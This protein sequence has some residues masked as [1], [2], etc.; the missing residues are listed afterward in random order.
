MKNKKLFT[1]T[2][3]LILVLATLSLAACGCSN[4][5][6][7]SE[8]LADF[9][10][11]DIS[12]YTGLAGYTGENPFVEVTV[13]DVHEMVEKKSTF[14]LFVSYKSC[15]WC[16]AVI[17]ELCEVA[18]E[19]NI[20][21]ANID[22]RKN[23]EWKSNLDIDD[24]DLFVEI[25]GDYLQYDTDGIKHLYVPHMFFV[26]DGAVVYEHQGAI[27]E[28]GSDPMTEKTPEM[29]EKI[30]EVFREGFGQLK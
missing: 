14:A 10:A 3:I 7:P 13:K 8:A 21:I 29:K 27:P 17:E 18:A 19:E 1:L 20:K 2:T 12:G 11:A 15:P 16:N 5:T 30:K 4:K 26:K 6:D 25:F 9:P 23:P 22:T 28:M 24:Y